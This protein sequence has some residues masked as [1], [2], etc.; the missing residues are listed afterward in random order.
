MARESVPSSSSPASSSAPSTSPAEGSC[1]THSTPVTRSLTHERE[2]LLLFPYNLMLCFRL[3]SSSWVHLV[4]LFCS[5]CWLLLRILKRH[6][7]FLSFSFI[8]FSMIFLSYYANICSLC[9]SWVW[10]TRL[11]CFRK[12][13][14]CFYDMM[15][16]CAP[17]MNYSVLAKH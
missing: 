5:S 14:N 16:Y 6:Y 3:S 2:G 10:F 12:S 17:K 8:R 1:S 15:F 9:M 13:S 4:L 11:F 7:W